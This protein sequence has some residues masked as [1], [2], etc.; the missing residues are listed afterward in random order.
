MLLGVE[1]KAGH[2]AAKCQVHSF[3][4][5]LADRLGVPHSGLAQ[6]TFEPEAGLLQRVGIEDTIGVAQHEVGDQ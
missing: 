4:R 2:Q 6:V 5:L 1:P 3:A